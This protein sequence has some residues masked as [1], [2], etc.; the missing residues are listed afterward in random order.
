VTIAMVAFEVVGLREFCRVYYVRPKLRDYTRLVLGT[1]L[2]QLMLA[3]AAC[4][5]VTRELRGERAW[6]KTTHRGAHR[7]AIDSG[8]LELARSGAAAGT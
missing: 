7:G 4:R 6:E 5:A 8:A 2:Y 3:A 1:P